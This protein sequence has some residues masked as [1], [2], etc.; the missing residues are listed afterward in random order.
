MNRDSLAD[1]CL[2]YA[3]ALVAYSLVNG[4]AFLVALGEPDLRCSIAAI[5]W[6]M[7]AL[8]LTLPIGSMFILR[9]LGRTEDRL[10]G[11]EDAS[12]DDSPPS[13]DAD[14]HRFLGRLRVARYVMVWLIAAM[15]VFGIA[16]AMGDT[17]CLEING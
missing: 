2:N 4:L 14:I 1:R 17:S 7:I 8:N 9:W 11:P 12:E 13:V 3:D 16:A 15:I 5:A 6:F 10:R